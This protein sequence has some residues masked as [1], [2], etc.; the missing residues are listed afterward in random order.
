MDDPRGGRLHLLVQDASSWPAW[1]PAASGTGPVLVA[2]ATFVFSD[3]ERPA[4]LAALLAVAVAPWIVEMIRGCPTGWPAQYITALALAVQH[5]GAEPLGLIDPTGGQQTSLLILCFTI[6]E[7]AATRAPTHAAVMTVIG[8]ITSVGSGL[9]DDHYDAAP[10]WTAGMGIGLFCGL[11][12]RRMLIALVDLK[13]AQDALRDDAVARERQRIAR[14]VH[15][16]IAHSMT[17]TMLH[18]TA[19]RMA[20]GRNDAGAATEALEEAER[21]GRRSLAD[22][23]STVGLLRA[24]DADVDVAT[25][26][27]LPGA[28]LDDLV[29]DYRAA[30]LR[31]DASIDDGVADLPAPVGLAV[32]RIVQEALANVGKHAAG[33]AASVWVRVGDIVDIEVVDDGTG[34]AAAD[35]GAGAGHGLL[36]MRERAESLGGT[37][38]AGPAGRGWRVR[39]TIPVG[40][41]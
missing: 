12:I 10:I 21:Q 8:V 17:V 26:T 18:I 6:G 20:V 34:A 13:E 32:H 11:L 3:V 27:A 39:A 41:P 9:L 19:A 1:L 40:A 23:R 30:G 24:P 14:E 35:A 29:A 4:L 15:D 22:I 16:V 38:E 2:L 33:A 28:E 31:V 7:T 25:A 36:G 5:L 37:F